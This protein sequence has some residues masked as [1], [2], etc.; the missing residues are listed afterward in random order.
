[1]KKKQTL[2]QILKDGSK[3]E[4]LALFSFNS[5]NTVDEVVL[6]FNLWVR[7]FFPDFFKIKDSLKHKELDESLVKLYKGEVSNFVQ[8]AYR[9]FGKTTRNKMFVAFIILNDEEQFRRFFRFLTYDTGSGSNFVTDVY[10]I[11]IQ[12]IIVS[13]YGKSFNETAKVKKKR[14]EK[15]REE[16]K[17]FFTTVN[18]FTMMTKTVG[19]A[20]RGAVIEDVRPHFDIYDDFEN[21]K[22]LRSAVLTNSIWLNMEEARNGLAPRFGVSLYTCNYLSESGNVHKLVEKHRD[23]PNS[24]VL[25]VPIWD[26]NKVPTWDIFTAEQ[27]QEILDNAEDPEG[28]YLCQPTS[29]K[30]AFFDRKRL[31]KLEARE[32]VKEVNGLKIFYEINQTHD[33][34]SGHDVARGVSL[35]SS[36]SVFWD[37]STFPARV[38]ATYHN[39]K[40]IPEAFG[41]EVSYQAKLFNRCL[42]GMENNYGD[43]A[44]KCLADNYDKNFIYHENWIK[45]ITKDNKKILGQNFLGFKTTSRSKE[46][47]LQDLRKAVKNGEVE[48]PDKNLLNELKSYSINDLYDNSIDPR[49]VTKHYDLLMACAIGYFMR[50]FK[51]KTERDSELYEDVNLFETQVSNL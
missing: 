9:G 1:M 14:E 50:K 44:V 31:N 36:T 12:P 41:S 23:N 24:K 33:Y 47:I 2:Q 8:I 27:I 6:K 25:I 21:S 4:H 18:G 43:S 28:E 45:E 3:S 40:I 7:F 42:V 22:S 37:F 19:Q 34:S 29:S 32:P 30:T 11:L 16:T 13:Y 10:N 5:N 46:I 48:I 39:N 17:H 26:K 15:K 20:Q 49:L 38:V 35:D 51:Y